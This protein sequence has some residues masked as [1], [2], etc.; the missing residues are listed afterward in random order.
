VETKSAP[1][2]VAKTHEVIHTSVEFQ[3]D[4]GALAPCEPTE[5][6]QL[7]RDPREDL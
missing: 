4:S 3:P 2:E 5:K 7:E 1:A 6:E